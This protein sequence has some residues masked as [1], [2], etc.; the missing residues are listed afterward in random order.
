MRA[1]SADMGAFSTRDGFGSL[2]NAHGYAVDGLVAVQIRQKPESGLVKLK[3]QSPA[4]AVSL[5]AL[6]Y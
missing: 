6:I 2:A 3:L 1:N 5:Y 4:I